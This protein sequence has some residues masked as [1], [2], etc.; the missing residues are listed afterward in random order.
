M[1]EKKDNEKSA[2]LREL[3][4]RTA[5]SQVEALVGILE[6]R[7]H[8]SQDELEVL[9]NA[10]VQRGNRRRLVCSVLD[11]SGNTGVR[12]YFRETQ[13]PTRPTDLL[14]CELFSYHVG[15][16]YNGVIQEF[17]PHTGQFDL[18]TIAT[19]FVQVRQEHREARQ[20]YEAELLANR[21]QQDQEKER[22]IQHRDMG[23]IL[24]DT[25]AAEF[26]V[27]SGYVVRN[28]RHHNW[29]GSY[30][31]G[32]YISHHEVRNPPEN[33]VEQVDITVNLTPRGREH[34][35]LAELAPVLSQIQTQVPDLPINI[36][37]GS[38]NKIVLSCT[39]TFAQAKALLPILKA[40]LEPLVCAE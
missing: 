16:L 33:L 25:L 39:V 24:L 18:A 17:R 32:L 23:A 14:S 30:L 35:T 15:H 11:T 22:I 7:D 3:Y 37:G 38:S 12:F 21:I 20:Q 29:S 6:N 28:I 10:T 8:V 1:P 31:P 40:A 19:R 36:F 5:T 13:H 34:F 26:L 4:T 2:A 9:M 27:D